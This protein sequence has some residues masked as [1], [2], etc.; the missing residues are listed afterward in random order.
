MCG[1]CLSTGVDRACTG[2]AP[3]R[4]R[5]VEGREGREGGEMEVL[6]SQCRA[7]LYMCILQGI[8]EV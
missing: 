5:D 7:C 3:R 1:V 2:C 6:Q 8:G 4:D